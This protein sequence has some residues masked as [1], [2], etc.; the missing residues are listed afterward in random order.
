ML[1]KLLYI[2]YIIFYILFWF[3]LNSYWLYNY[4]KLIT[5]HII[6]IIIICNNFPLKLDKKIKS[7]IT[8]KNYLNNNLGNDGKIIR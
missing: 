4:N 2:F 8:I 5:Y 6:Y 1:N 7:N 3:W